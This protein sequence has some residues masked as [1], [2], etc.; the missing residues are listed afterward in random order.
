MLHGVQQLL[1]AEHVHVQMV[2]ALI[3]VAIHHLHQIIGTLLLAVSQRIGVDG[4]G[5]GDAIQ[6]PMIG[7]LRSRVQR[8]QQ[9]V[10][11][12]T[13]AGV[14][15]RRQRL[16]RLATIGHGASRLAIHHVGGDG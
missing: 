15:A 14:C 1:L 6:R 5:V 12:R 13:V 10:L 2:R 11:L 9:T 4:L 16:A 3:E 8:G 7:Q